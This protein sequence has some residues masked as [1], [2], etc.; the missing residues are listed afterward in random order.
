[1]RD[2]AHGLFDFLTSIKHYVKYVI[3]QVNKLINS[4]FANENKETDKS[5]Q[6][7]IEEYHSTVDKITSYNYRSY[8]Y[9]RTT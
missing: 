6:Q 8:F 3:K 1:M 2:V 5:K 7:L 4:I 9:L